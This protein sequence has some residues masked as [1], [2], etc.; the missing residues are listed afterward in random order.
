MISNRMVSISIL[1]FTYNQQDLIGRTLDSVLKQKEWG[2]GE[3]VI[4]DDCSTDNNWEVIQSYKEKYPQ[5]IR[6][7]R[8][9][10]NLGMYRNLERAYQLRGSADFYGVLAGDDTCTDGYLQH[11]QEMVDN[12]KIDV[13]KA[14]AICFDFCV[15][16]PNGIKMNVTINRYLKKNVSPYRLKFRGFLH[17]RGMVFSEELMAKQK[18]LA[19][20]KTVTLAESLVEIQPFKN[21][22]KI[23]YCP[24]VANEY[25]SQIGVSTTMRDK[26]HYKNDMEKWEYIL[27]HWNLCKKD[28][29]YALMRKNLLDYAYSPEFGKLLN[30]VKYYFLSRDKDI[31]FNILNTLLN[32]RL[33]IKSTFRI[34]A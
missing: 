24:F 14:V 18:Y 27:E 17:A 8:N 10:P 16:R 29:N 12:N 28:Q 22:E 5:Y 19:D 30:I 3:I 15:I 7:Y 6:A 21:A 33:V 23:Y 11:I 31:P 4:C 9:N 25:Y 2:L 32:L 13:G 20:G 34:G 26:T 1:V